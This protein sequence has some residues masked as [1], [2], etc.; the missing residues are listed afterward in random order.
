VCGRRSACSLRRAS[1][2][3]GV[4]WEKTRILAE[5]PFSSR[6]RLDK[7]AFARVLSKGVNAQKARL[8]AANGPEMG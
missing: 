8:R 3:K 2:A 1:E 4:F 7:C 6:K 5:N